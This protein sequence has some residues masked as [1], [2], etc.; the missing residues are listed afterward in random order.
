MPRGALPPSNAPVLQLTYNYN[1][2]PI[3]QADGGLGSLVLAAA[4]G[5]AAA[6]LRDP[7]GYKVVLHAQ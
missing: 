6:E 7:E 1:C 5:A 3:Q 2:A 4:D